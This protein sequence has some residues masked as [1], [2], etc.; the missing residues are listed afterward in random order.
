MALIK[1]PDCGKEM[2]DQ[3]ASCLNCGHPIKPVVIEQTAKK[4][5]GRQAFYIILLV[6]GFLMLLGS[7]ASLP[8]SMGFTL[9][10]LLFIVAGA[11]GYIVSRFAAWWHHG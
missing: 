6:A 8:E 11:V 1:C 4:F 10:S 7:F 3:A 2:S 5:K 9:F